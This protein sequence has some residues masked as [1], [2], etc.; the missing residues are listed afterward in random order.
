MRE[1]VEGRVPVGETFAAMVC[2]EAAWVD[3]EFAAIVAA[4]FGG[5]ADEVLVPPAARR[6]GGRVPSA[7]LSGPGAPGWRSGEP[8]DRLPVEAWARQRSP[9]SHPCLPWAEKVRIDMALVSGR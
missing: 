2:A 3:A 1:Y 5:L 9:P 7:P 4:N 8:G 6:E